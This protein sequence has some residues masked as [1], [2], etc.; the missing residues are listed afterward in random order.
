[1]SLIAE[2]EEVSITSERLE[3]GGQE[4]RQKPLADL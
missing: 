2:A 3:S 4:R 1:M